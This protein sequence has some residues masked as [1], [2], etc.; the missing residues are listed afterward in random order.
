MSFA[1]GMKQNKGE[2]LREMYTIA[3]GRCGVLIDSYDVGEK[4]RFDRDTLETIVESW[5]RKGLS[6][7]MRGTL[8]ASLKLNG[9]EYVESIE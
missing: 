4:H 1:G 9:V 8:Y 5:S 7:R 6:R 2:L 3:E